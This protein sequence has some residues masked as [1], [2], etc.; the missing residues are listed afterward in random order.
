MRD[1]IPKTAPDGTSCLEVTLEGSQLLHNPLLNKGTAFPKEERIAFCLEVLLP[2]HSSNLEV[3]VARVYENFQRHTSNLEKYIYL[4]ALQ[5][6]NEVLFY[7]LL[8]RHLEE[9]IPI[10]YTPTVGEAVQ[11][12]S[13]IYSF[14]RGLYISPENIEYLKETIDHIPSRQIEMIVVTDNQGILGIGDQGVG[15]MGIPIG[16]L[17]LYTLAAGIHPSLC[18]PISLDVGTNNESLLKDPLYL[19]MKHKRYTNEKY[20]QF[21]ETF[22]KEIT[23]C[24]PHA[25]IQWE[26]LSKQN[27]FTILDRYRNTCLSFNDDVQGTGA[28]AVAGILNAVRIKKERL[29]DQIFCVYGAGAGGI[30]VTRQIYNT[31][32][33]E[34]LTSEKA[35]EKIFVLDSK[36]LMM[37]TQKKL[38]DYKR[39]FATQKEGYGTTLLDVVQNAKVTILLGLSG[40]PNSFTKPIVEAMTKNTTRPVIFSLSNPN[41]K[42]EASPQDLIEWSKGQAI[43][44]TGSPFEP[45]HYKGK[46][47]RVGQGN[48][49]FIFPGVGLGALAAK[50]SKIT[51]GMFTVAAYTLA[52]WTSKFSQDQ[53]MVYPPIEKLRS[54]SV[55]VAEAV[56]HQ[57]VKEGVAKAPKADQRQI[58][59]GKM[60]EPAYVAFKK[61]SR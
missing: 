38:E 2:P 6:R 54:V 58:I 37:A 53:E 40:S 10:I 51:D 30:G 21:I 22:V 34:G 57:A 3:Q 55:D 48:N 14:A 47:V 20:A 44:A 31:L 4:R 15:G 5:D 39:F 33:K 19:G 13:H 50:A 35:K 17:S 11:L 52:K 43:V 1:Y 36:G 7:A 25:L 59:L 60:W 12:H 27:A 16:K 24:Y 56:F 61:S 49:V 46:Q 42:A 18:L 29:V 45:F 28:V 8:N 32:I 41:S 9:M 23:R 26:D